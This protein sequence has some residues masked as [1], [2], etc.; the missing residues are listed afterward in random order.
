MKQIEYLSPY[1]PYKLLLVSPVNKIGGRIKIVLRGGHLIG[2]GL[3]EDLY[4]PVMRHIDDID[5][6]ETGLDDITI[7]AIKF[8]KSSSKLPHNS[9]DLL[10]HAIQY[11][12]I[13][14]LIKN[15]FDIFNLIEKG[16][17]ID[18]KTIV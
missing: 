1:L 2:D 15:H 18:L 14:V 16:L 12:H 6:V 5:T 11:K 4:K 8:C 3:S 7:S 13:L 9:D 17:A 10:L